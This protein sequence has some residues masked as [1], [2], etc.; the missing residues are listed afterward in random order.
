MLIQGTNLL[1]FRSAYFV[2]KS[3]DPSVYFI[4][5]VTSD[6]GVILDVYSWITYIFIQPCF[7]DKSY[8]C[9]TSSSDRVGLSASRFGDTWDVIE[10]TCLC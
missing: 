2:N 7:G 6:N 10:K 1:V 3:A 9:C 5:S 4:L 8:Q